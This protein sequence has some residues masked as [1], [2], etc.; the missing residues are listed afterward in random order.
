MMNPPFAKLHTHLID[1]G[2]YPAWARKAGLPAIAPF[3]AYI[4]AQAQG[5][6][7]AEFTIQEAA[8]TFAKSEKTIKR[9]LTIGRKYG[10]FRYYKTRKGVVIVYHTSL[11]KVCQLLNVNNW[12]A[13]AE[14]HLDELKHAKVLATEIQ[15]E[16][17]QRSS[18]YA[19]K[20]KAREEGY[21]GEIAKPENLITSS[22]IS[23]GA[24]V[25]HISERYIY[26]SEDFKL[27]G[28]SQK[29]IG[30]ALGRSERTIR[31]RL[32]NRIRQKKCLPPVLKR[33]LCQTKPEYKLKY[34]FYKL[35]SDFD[36]SESKRLFQFSYKNQNEIYRAECNLYVFSHILCSCRA[37]RYF[38]NRFLQGA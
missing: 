21:R 1:G 27:Y 18:R 12:G 11:F 22:A 29:G 14:V 31:R 24:L 8:F 5:T 17:M 2:N 9:W 3:W 26:V 38:F 33:Q 28:T 30:K 13:T 6:G 10:L 37:R 16:Q 23:T 36:D 4:R 35:C 15:A 34:Q 19:A 20:Q 7:K 32:S 25:K